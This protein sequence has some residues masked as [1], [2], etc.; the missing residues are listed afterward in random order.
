[1]RRR[2]RPESREESES[3][4]TVIE[5]VLWTPVLFGA[6]AFA[7]QAGLYLWAEHVAQDAAQQAAIT[8]QDE[9]ASD[10]VHWYSDSRQAGLGQISQLAPNLLLDPHVDPGQQGTTVTVTVQA[11][12]PEVLFPFLTHVSVSSSGPIEQ[13]TKP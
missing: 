11:S 5:F 3:G 10:P 12:V 1:M 6:I 13:W 9:Y 4:Q 8:A 2:W 7:I